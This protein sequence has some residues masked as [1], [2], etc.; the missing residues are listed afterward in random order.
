VNIKTIK[1]WP[2][3]ICIKFRIKNTWKVKKKYITLR[4]CVYYIKLIV[5]LRAFCS[6]GYYCNCGLNSS[7]FYLNK[8]FDSC[9]FFNNVL[10]FHINLYATL[11]LAGRHT[12]ERHTVT[13]QNAALF[14]NIFFLHVELKGIIFVVLHKLTYL[15]K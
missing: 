11:K 14:L 13:Q 3:K 5:F 12:A 4:T 1:R 2:F 6:Y 7:R 10:I 15:Y 8:N 9:P